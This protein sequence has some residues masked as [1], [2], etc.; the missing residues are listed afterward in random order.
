MSNHLP[1]QPE[2]AKLIKPSSTLPDILRTTLIGKPDDRIFLIQ[3]EKTLLSFIDSISDSLVIG[4][5]NSYYR[6]LSHQVAEYYGLNHT[7]MRDKG[8]D[9]SSVKLLLSKP[10]NYVKKQKPT[11]ESLDRDMHVKSQE[12]NSSSNNN[13]TI[14]TTA[15]AAPKLEPKKKFKI[16]KRDISSTDSVSNAERVLNSSS[17]ATEDTTMHSEL[18]LEELRLQKEKIYEGLKSKIF[19]D[20]SDEEKEDETGRKGYVADTADILSEIDTK[21]S[22]SSASPSSDRKYDFA[23]SPPPQPSSSSSFSSLNTNDRGPRHSH[24]NTRRRWR[25]KSNG[26]YQ[27]QHQYQFQYQNPPYMQFYPKYSAYQYNGYTIPNSG[28]MYPPDF[29]AYGYTGC[30]YP[31]PNE[32]GSQPP[33]MNP[34]SFAP[35][36]YNSDTLGQTCYAPNSGYSNGQFGVDSNGNYYPYYYYYNKYNNANLVGNSRVTNGNEIPGG[37]SN[38]DTKTEGS[39]DSVNDVR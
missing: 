7:V 39:N 1:K 21:T 28:I 20:T 11:I 18:S 31:A 6:L 36:V 33:M 8:K 23:Y 10:P 32:V 35:V 4:P 16:L 19:S 5:F 22:S 27:N 25:A 26:E 30:T 29:N 38:Q 15:V 13:A 24:R 17:P 2:E 12:I 3:L 37:S 34:Q 14:S 9:C